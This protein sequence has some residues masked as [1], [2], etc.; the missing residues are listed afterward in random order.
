MSG[1]FPSPEH[2]HRQFR[3]H[4]PSHFAFLS[5][6]RHMVHGLLSYFVLFTLRTV[7]TEPSL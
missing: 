3:G 4:P 5:A 1:R 7:Y 6:E 2:F